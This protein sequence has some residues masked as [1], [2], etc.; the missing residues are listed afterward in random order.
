MSPISRTQ[1]RVATA[2][3]VIM[4][5]V[6]GT[7]ALI[8]TRSVMIPFIFSALIAFTVAPIVGFFETK[9]KVKRWLS[10]TI[11]TGLVFSS[12]VLL[13]AMI[14]GTVKKA[15]RNLDTYQER[16]QE[17][18]QQIFVKAEEFGIA[19]QMG[20][21]QESFEL[22]Y[23]NIAKSTVG[24]LGDVVGNTSLIVIIVLFMLSGKQLGLPNA[25]I[26]RDVN[27]QIRTYLVTK[28]VASLATGVLTA[29]ILGLVGLDMAIM[30][31][32]LAFVLN[33]IPTVGSI[34]AAALPI[35]VALLQ[36]DSPWKMGIAIVLPGVVQFVVGNVLEPKILGDTLD[37]HP[38]TVM[39]ALMFWGLVWGVPGMIL[40]TPIVVIAKICLLRIDGGRMYA[41]LLA[42]ELPT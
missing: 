28:A 21:W 22:P 42:G 14:T 16:V 6:A 34:V 24:T 3:L 1:S 20:E 26:W 29:L 30:F 15:M 4:A 31:G 27:R 25:G 39:L 36:F 35:P 18:T 33:F 23:L 19:T 5:G 38:V 32:V 9:L 8:Y 2:C 7:A 12:M 13:V 41:N 40:A 37:L 11:T 17:L 10:L